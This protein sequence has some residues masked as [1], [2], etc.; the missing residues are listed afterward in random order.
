[1]GIF[2]T[3]SE[4][5]G[6]TISTG[7]YLFVHWYG[8]VMF[9]IAGFYIVRKLYQ[10]KIIDD[11]VFSNKRIFLHIKIEK[12]NLQSTLAVE[13]IF[14]SMHAMHQNFTWAERW[15]E[16][17]VNL[18]WTAEMVSLGGKIS[19]IISVPEKSR[20]L[21][22]SSFY[23]YYPNAEIS[24][25]EDYMKNLTHLDDNSSWDMWGTEYKFTRDWAYPIR[26]WREFEH[27]AAEEPVIDPMAG[28]LE[29][30]SR[31]EPHEMLAI[32]I[33]MRP[34]AD[35]EWAPHSEEV[36]Q[37]LKEEGEHHVPFLE[38]ILPFL[39]W[40]SKKTVIEAMQEGGSH[41]A[42]GE[43]QKQPKVMRMTEG[44]RNTV[45]GIE[46]KA[47]KPAYQTKI[48]HLY[49]APK[50]KFDKNKKSLLVGAYRQFGAVNSNNLKPDVNGTWTNYNYAMFE[51][52]EKPFVKFMIMERKHLLLKGFVNRSRWIGID[53]MIMNIE[54]LATLYHFP[55][56]TASTPPV[57]RIDIKK[58]QPP[59]NLP[60]MG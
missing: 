38:R 33:V 36:V 60:V 56:N 20:G 29:A 1:M 55:L 48:R 28:V 49:I 42:H 22:L 11:Y 59:A 37:S 12:E 7:W 26:T 15:L 53:P 21:A 10:D 19:F 31:A 8:W 5:F 58:G 24:E 25:V 54:E 57:E 50:D 6:S 47:T 13:Q 41:G 51:A 3:I 32:Q 9:V 43:E 52:L 27:P 46:T 16:G 14:A 44:E 17:L 2:S 39:A 4:G 40:G 23:A 18:W 45:K 34:V 35:K 30:L